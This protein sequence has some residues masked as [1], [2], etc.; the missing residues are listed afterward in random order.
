MREQNWHSKVACSILDET[1]L[2][3]RKQRKGK[4]DVALLHIIR[5]RIDGKGLLRS[6]TQHILKTTTCVEV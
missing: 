5:H 3:T 6:L 1:W 2:K 4:H